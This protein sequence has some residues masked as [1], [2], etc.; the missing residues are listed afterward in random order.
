MGARNIGSYLG[1]SET[2]TVQTHLP[3]GCSRRQVR[4]RSGRCYELVFIPTVGS[5]EE[6]SEA[7]YLATVADHTPEAHAIY[8]GA[9]LGSHFKITLPKDSRLVPPAS[10]V[11]ASG[12]N[13]KD[14]FIRKG[15]LDVIES[16]VWQ[17][18]GKIHSQTRRIVEQIIRRGHRA[19]VI[20]DHRQDL[21]VIE[22][23]C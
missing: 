19:I 5:E 17:M 10:N 9:L 18:G 2:Q 12:I 15:T 20:A 3:V 22:V 4:L 21:G 7:A 6:L 11:A 1:E 13:L 14:R 23:V 8:T 16:W